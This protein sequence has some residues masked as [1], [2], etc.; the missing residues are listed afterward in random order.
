MQEAGLLL[1]IDSDLRRETEASREM[2]PS[3]VACNPLATIAAV[4]DAR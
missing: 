3:A 2:Q 4:K 1:N